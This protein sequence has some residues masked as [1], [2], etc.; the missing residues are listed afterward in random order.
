MTEGEPG[1]RLKHFLTRHWNLEH[2]FVFF[3]TCG[4][5]HTHCHLLS[6]AVFSSQHVVDPL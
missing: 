5:G 3:K 6:V 2:V 4:K 1:Q